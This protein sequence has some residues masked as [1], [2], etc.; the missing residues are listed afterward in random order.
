MTLWNNVETWTYRRIMPET[1]V[2]RKVTMTGVALTVSHHCALYIILNYR[3]WSLSCKVVVEGGIKLLMQNCETRSRSLSCK[4]VWRRRLEHMD[5][6]CQTGLLTLRA[7]TGNHF[8][9]ANFIHHWNVKSEPC[10]DLSIRMRKDS[11]RSCYII[12]PQIQSHL[13]QEAQIQSHL[14]QEAQI[15]SHLDQEAPI[16]SH[17]DQETH[18]ESALSFD[19]IGWYRHSRL[20]LDNASQWVRA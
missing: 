6:D 16:Q 4:I 13:D 8:E 15:Q 14:D 5:L 1:L 12:L 9:L 18:D 3:S 10:P 17:L 7:T 20:S 19:V 2:L 11:P